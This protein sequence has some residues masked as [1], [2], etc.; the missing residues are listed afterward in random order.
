M[1]DL[2]R[3]VTGDNSLDRRTALD[4]AFDAIYYHEQRLAARFQAGVDPLPQF[5]ELRDYA[6]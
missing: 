3:T 2:G 4:R 5:Q 6:D 1:A